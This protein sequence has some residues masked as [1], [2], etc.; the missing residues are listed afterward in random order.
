VD[1]SSLAFSLCLPAE[2]LPGSLD[3]SEHY[4]ACTS[5]DLHLLL[6]ISDIDL[7]STAVDQLLQLRS[8]ALEAVFVIWVPFQAP[9]RESPD[10]QSIRDLRMVLP[11]WIRSQTLQRRLGRAKILYNNAWF[12]LARG[13]YKIAETMARETVSIREDIESCRL[14]AHPSRR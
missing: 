7:R 11:I 12:V 6:N 3:A 1:I 14:T 10:L 2:V 5:G 8:L 4:N 9:R 13:N